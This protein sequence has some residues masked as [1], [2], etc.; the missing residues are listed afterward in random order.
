[1]NT[2]DPNLKDYA[3]LEEED[4]ILIKAVEEFGVG[5]W[6]DVAQRIPGRTDNQVSAKRKKC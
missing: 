4:E 2:L 6:T 5:K 3:F 1:V